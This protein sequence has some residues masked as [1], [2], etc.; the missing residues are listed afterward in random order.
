MLM[1]P[2]RPEVIPRPLMVVHSQRLRSLP[3][4]LGMEPV[5]KLSRLKEMSLLPSLELLLP[6]S[7]KRSKTILLHGTSKI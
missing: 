4:Q 3:R 7:D 6:H 1:L 5:E 2:S